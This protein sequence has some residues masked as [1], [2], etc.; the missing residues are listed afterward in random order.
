MQ[1]MSLKTISLSLIAFIFLVGSGIW[2]YTNH[3]PLQKEAETNN[4]FI[5]TSF[6][7][8]YFLTK[9]IAGE[10]AEV[11]NLTKTGG[12]PHDYEP[13]TKDI[14]SI[15]NSQLLIVNGA[16]FESWLDKFSDE[17]NSKQ[18]KVL[19]V[20]EGLASLKGVGHDH[21]EEN[22]EEEN[23]EEED[24]EEEQ[25]DP[26]VWL[27]P[28]LV[29]TQVNIITAKLKEID[30]SNTNYYE[31]NQQK[32]ISELQKLDQEFIQGLSACKQHKIVTSHAAFAYL[33]K[34]YGFEQIAIQGLNPDEDP[35][36]AKIAATAELARENKINYI[37]FETLVSPKIA[38]TIAA[39][40]GAKTLV[41]NPLEGLTP[42]DEVSGK[43]YF[44]IQREN[45]ANLRLALNCQ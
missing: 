29:Q 3:K 34:R 38:Q 21:G 2:L 36:P 40:V 45:L 44:S 19:K 14:M 32:L 35:S 17:I 25:T 37:F 28:V 43:N 23:H 4:L 33:A 31:Q 13:S 39:E 8:L 9:E 6:Y 20:A 41:F 18:T 22:H 11:I 15:E 12:E 7:P 26:H 1:K 16:F 30:A 5:T 42:E 27:D 10:K 24:H